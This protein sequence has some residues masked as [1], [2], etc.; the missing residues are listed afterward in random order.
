MSITAP[1]TK[2]QLVPFGEYQAVLVSVDDGDPGPHGPLWFWSFRITTGDQEGVEL[3][4]ISSTRYSNYP[5]KSYRW[6]RALG[7][8]PDIDF[9]ASLI[10]GRPCRLQVKVE[11]R[12]DEIGQKLGE[13]NKL[14]EILAPTKAQLGG[15]MSIPDQKAAPTPADLPADPV[16][17]PPPV[18]EQLPL[19]S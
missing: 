14:D 10:E 18:G 2:T 12:L 5:S 3:V 16:G 19:T 9:N 1:L 17:E 13:R 11:E 15:G 7:H 6:A 4:G 8:P